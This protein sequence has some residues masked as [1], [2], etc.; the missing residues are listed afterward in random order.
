METRKGHYA[1]FRWGSSARGK[2]LA[3]LSDEARVGPPGWQSTERVNLHTG[4]LEPASRVS[5][6]DASPP[7]LCSA[8]MPCR[9]HPKTTLERMLE[10]LDAP[11]LTALD[12]RSP[13]LPGHTPSTARVVQHA[14]SQPLGPIGTSRSRWIAGGLLWGQGIPWIPRSSHRSHGDSGSRLPSQSPLQSQYSLAHHI[15]ASCRHPSPYAETFAGRGG[16]CG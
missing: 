15:A 8:A 9:S 1:G 16:A 2:T 14:L 4:N 7:D 11:S 5:S 6:H 13:L 10:A 12:P 3:R